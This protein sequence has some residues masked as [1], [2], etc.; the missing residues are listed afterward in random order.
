M[1]KRLDLG[2]WIQ[3]Q[4]LLRDWKWIHCSL[5]VGNKLHG[6]KG[7]VE[8]YFS[9][10]HK[11]HFHAFW[12]SRSATRE[13]LAPQLGSASLSW[14]NAGQAGVLL[15]LPPNS[16]QHSEQT[17]GSLKIHWKLAFLCLQWGEKESGSGGTFHPLKHPSR[18]PPS[19]Q[20]ASPRN[21][22]RSKQRV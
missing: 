22:K 9:A 3:I 15:P 17:I 21:A 7:F 11:P 10:P 14:V 8:V 18:S 12:P 2:L 19:L 4:C 6:E 20:Q 5:K 1:I 16:S 13:S